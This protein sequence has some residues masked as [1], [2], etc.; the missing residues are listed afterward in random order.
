MSPNPTSKQLALVQALFDAGV[1][2]ANTM[3]NYL[4]EL[5]IQSRMSPVEILSSGQLQVKLLSCVGVG[6]AG[7]MELAYSGDFDGVAQLL[8]PEE[9]ATVLVDAIADRQRRQLDLDGIRTQTLS[10]V[11]NIFFNGLMGS[12]ANVTDRGITYMAPKFREGT[13]KQLLAARN[14]PLE[15][16]AIFG[17]TQ[18]QIQQLQASGTIIIF[19]EVSP[20][21]QFLTSVEQV[22]R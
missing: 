3:L 7:A 21:E 2:R 19:F 14:R 8:F 1:S 11:G 12:I 18:F 15:G 20:L 13:V 9:T 17:Q 4:T 16:A 22:D 10:E 5:P 6:R